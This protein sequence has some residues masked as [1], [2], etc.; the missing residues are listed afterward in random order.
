MVKN[1]PLLRA[2]ANAAFLFFFQCRILLLF[3][4]A[5][6]IAAGPLANNEAQMRV[7]FLFIE[8]VF[9][10]KGEKS[11]INQRNQY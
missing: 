6:R 3:V 7:R 9:S 10:R 1:M 11:K 4:S 8:F 2:G 5:P